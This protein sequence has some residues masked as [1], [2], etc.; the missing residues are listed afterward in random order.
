ME[1]R[2]VRRQLQ[3]RTHEEPDNVSSANL[4]RGQRPERPEHERIREFIHELYG[5]LLSLAEAARSILHWPPANEIAPEIPIKRRDPNDRGRTTSE[6]KARETGSDKTLADSFPSTDPPSTI[7]DP[8][9]PGG[10]RKAFDAN[11]L[12]PNPE[13]DTE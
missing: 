13:R 9:E 12:Q 11:R 10:Q 2:G 6:E 8:A 5:E 7:P 4:D 3:K 1:D